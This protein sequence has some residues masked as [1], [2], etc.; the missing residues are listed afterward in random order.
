MHSS[1]IAWIMRAIPFGTIIMYGALGETVTEKSG[2]LNLGVPGIMYL[3]GF[4][5]FASAWAYENSAAN[6]NG[7]VSILIALSCAILAS[8]AGGLIYAF[9]T[10][11]LR[12]NGGRDALREKTEWVLHSI[13]CRAAIKAGDRT[14]AAEMLALAQRI[15]DGTVPPFCPHGRPCVLKIT[16]KELEKQ[17]GR[18]V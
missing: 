7:F 12:A 2:N 11:S 1:L 5:G 18:L 14:N 3:G 17:F 6:P 8:M 13:A 9:L 15:M 16:R 10:I 4:A